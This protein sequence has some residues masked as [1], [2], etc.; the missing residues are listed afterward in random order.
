MA[1]VFD[2]LVSLCFWDTLFFTE[3]GYE[4]TVHS[5]VYISVMFRYSVMKNV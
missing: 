5:L 3:D 4:E 2:K 1:F